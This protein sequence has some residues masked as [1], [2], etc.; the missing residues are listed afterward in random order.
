MKNFKSV[1]MGFVAGAMCV[2]SVTAMAAYTDVT[3]KLWND[4][5]F[6]FNGVSTPAPSNQPV[7]NYNGYTY[8]PLRFVTETLGG[9]T[10]YD[11][12]SKTVSV[13]LTSGSNVVEKEVE[14]IKEVPVY[15]EKDSSGSS[16]GKDVKYNYSTLPVK[17]KKDYYTLEITGVTRSTYNNTT[18]VLINFDND[19]DGSDYYQLVPSASKLTVNGKNIALT[20]I[21]NQQDNSWY[22]GDI[23]PDEEKDGYVT[24]DLTEDGT[25]NCD[26]ELTVKN[27]TSGKEDVHTFHF[28]Y[29]AGKDSDND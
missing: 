4:V 26:L 5:K 28:V 27:N 3:A 24:F 19:K 22:L 21:N 2:V 17:S 15:I 20:K 14:V 12:S 25:L 6:N 10:S 9:Q 29:E 1:A 7:L 13:N 16:D 8:V 23:G 18:K 11:D